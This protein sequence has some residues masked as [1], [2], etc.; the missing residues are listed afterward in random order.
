MNNRK[1][2]FYKDLSEKLWDLA[3]Y[4]EK[5]CD[6]ESY[7]KSEEGLNKQAS[8]EQPHLK[9]FP[10][11]KSKREVLENLGKSQVIG[12]ENDRVN[13]KTA[14]KSSLVEIKKDLERVYSEPNPD[15]Y[16]GFHLRSASLNDKVLECDLTNKYDFD[17]AFRVYENEKGLFVEP[18]SDFNRKLLYKAKIYNAGHIS[19][20]L[21]NWSLTLKEIQNS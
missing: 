1:S 9:A 13:L 17:L 4:I 3:S 10:V 5:T 2:K 21:L 18:S 8:L 16:Q 6:G 15:S 20:T 19:N 11:S 14:S 12:A 7:V